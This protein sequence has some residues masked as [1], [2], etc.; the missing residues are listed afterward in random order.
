MKN[1]G[2]RFKM[3]KSLL[4]MHLPGDILSSSQEE[5]IKHCKYHNLSIGNS[6]KVSVSMC[7]R[8]CKYHGKNNMGD[9]M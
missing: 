1:D 3:K 4:T 2:P 5:C 9:E 6:F 7:I 8:Q